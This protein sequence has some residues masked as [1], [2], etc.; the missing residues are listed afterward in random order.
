MNRDE[1][2]KRFLATNPQGLAYH[3]QTLKE[4]IAGRPFAFVATDEGL[5]VVIDGETGHCQIRVCSREHAEQAAERANAQ[6][7]LTQA[8]IDALVEQSLPGGSR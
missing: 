1:A 8:Q 4:R 7:H 6:L 2:I 5:S 3:K